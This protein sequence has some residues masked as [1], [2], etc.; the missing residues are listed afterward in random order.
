MQVLIHCPFVIDEMDLQNIVNAYYAEP[1][2]TIVSTVKL[3]HHGYE[4]STALVT[5]TNPISIKNTYFGES[6]V[7]LIRDGVPLVMWTIHPID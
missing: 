2:Q 3:F 5:L 4:N 6:I 1:S 7:Y